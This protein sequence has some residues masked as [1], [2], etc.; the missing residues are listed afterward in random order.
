MLKTFKNE[1]LNYSYQGQHHQYYYYTTKP[2]KDA[3]P[4]DE[5]AMDVDAQ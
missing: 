4:P 2:G 3:P 1:L 5:D